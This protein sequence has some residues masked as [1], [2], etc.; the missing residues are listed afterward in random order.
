M[1]E[2][3]IVADNF[4]NP[5]VWVTKD[6]YGNDI[7]IGL[8]D[9]Q[10]YLVQQLPDGRFKKLQPV[11]APIPTI[12]NNVAF[13]NSNSGVTNMGG[14]PQHPQ[15]AVMD[16]ITLNTSNNS[17]G[18]MP[19]S[20]TNTSYSTDYTETVS[21]SKYNNISINS[22]YEPVEQYQ[23][24]PQTHEPISV[25]PASIQSWFKPLIDEER[26]VIDTIIDGNKFTYIIKNK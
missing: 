8:I 5:V 11:N 10:T 12:N 13:P 2:R 26:E 20:T 21:T 4:G 16:N 3:V 7:T 19:G 18:Y 22:T 23:P 25:I 24:Q 6:M 15:H 14:Y 9:G 1:N 17:S